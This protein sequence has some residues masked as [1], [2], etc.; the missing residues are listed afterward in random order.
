[1]VESSTPDKTCRVVLVAPLAARRE[2]LALIGAICLIILLMGVRFSLL[3]SAKDS[4]LSMQPYQMSDIYLKS[5]APVLYRSLLGV[6]GDILD[7]REE[8]GDWPDVGQLK[9]EALPPFATAFLPTALRGYVWERHGGKGW[10]DYYGINSDVGKADKE[11]V[12]PLANSFILRIIDLKSKD[13]PHPHFGRHNDP[14]MLYTFQ[15]WTNPQTVDYPAGSLVERGWKW[16]IRSGALA[17]EKSTG[18]LT[19]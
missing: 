18:V 4:R 10:V 9:K 11:A 19:Q 17:E 7:L 3:P 1:M 6:V 14:K 16:I 5:Q 13:H 2:A 12:D 15:V 8:T